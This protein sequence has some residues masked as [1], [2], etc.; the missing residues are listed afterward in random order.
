LLKRWLLA[1]VLMFAITLSFATQ[2]CTFSA[3]MKQNPVRIASAANGPLAGVFVFAQGDNGSGYA[4]TGVLGNYSMTTGLQTGTYNVT[5]FAYGYINAERDFINVTAGQTT[6]GIN[7]DLMASGGISGTVTDAVNGTPISDAFIYANLSNGTGTFAWYNTTGSDG[8]YLMDTNLPTGM[9]NVSVIV[10]PDGYIRNMTTANVVAGAETRNIN[11]QLARSG[12]ISGKVTAPN[13][14]GLFGITVIALSSGPTYYGYATTNSSGNY[15]IATGL[16]TGNY[17]VYASGAGNF[18]MYMTPVAVTAGQETSGINMELTPVTTP[19]TPSGT[20]TG[21]ITD[22]NSNPILFASVTATGSGGTG[23]DETDNNGYYNISSGLGTGNDYNVSATASGYYDAF[24]PTLVNVTVDQTTSNIDIQMTAQPAETFGTIT[25]T[26]TGTPRTTAVTVYIN[27]D[28]G[29]VPSS[30]PISSPDNTT[31]T[32]TGNISYPTYNGIV[33]QRSNI[34]INGNGYTLQGNQSGNGL[35]LPGI[36]NVTIKNTNIENFTFGI[37]L[38]SSSNNAIYHNNFMNNT[39]QVGIYNSTNTWHNGYPSGGNFWS[40]YNGTDLYGGPYQNQTG[41][42]GIGDTPYI[43]GGNDTDRYPLMEPLSGL[44]ILEVQTQAGSNVSVSPVGNVTVTFASVSVEG[45][46]AWNIV[47]PPTD[48]FVSVTCNE[49][50]TSASYSGNVTLE[51]GYDPSGLSLQDQQAIKI[52]LWNDSSSCWV[53]ITTSVNTTSHVVYGTSPHLSMFGV[54]S[55]LGITGDLGLTGTTTVS[56]PANPPPPPSYWM[57]LNYYEINTTK[58]L[59]PPISLRLAYS[60][61][62]IQPGQELSVRMM[63]WDDTS[64]RWVD[65][66]TGVDTTNHVVFGLAPHLSMFGV[67]CLQPTSTL[68]GGGSRMPYMD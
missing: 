48:Q 43:I 44:G 45:S 50:R 62:S 13:G 4:T 7:F 19:P 26:V 25:G 66:T 22:Q 12:F 67:T 46:T 23:S 6:A 14:T 68:G 39:N 51:F 34:V 5:T 28:G 38:S 21:R 57:A 61:Q 17:T 31:Y 2:L 37:S 11:L 15:R 24:Y 64:S 56:L 53:D 9:Y 63:M 16:A 10:A 20:V 65:I 32:F 59:P 33:V 40:S 60:Y 42:D 52:W 1:D 47:Q 29:V 55:N 30:A 27:S 18:T 35:S 41:Y 58:A 8:K 36:S 54:T 3:T 49:I